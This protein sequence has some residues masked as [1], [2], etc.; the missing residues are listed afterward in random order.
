MI[1]E[2]MVFNSLECDRE[3]KQRM[4]GTR[5]NVFVIVDK[6]LKT[7]YELL[8]INQLEVEKIPIYI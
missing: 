5:S 3:V 1:F 8:K 4:F 2:E 6:M 7:Y